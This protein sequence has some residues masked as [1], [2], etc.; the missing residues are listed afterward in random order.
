MAVSIDLEVIGSSGAASPERRSTCFRIGRELAVDG[1]ALA[2]GIPVEEQPGVR[3][4]L[5]TH[6]H[7][8]H[9]RELPLFLDNVLALRS[10]AE[11]GGRRAPSRPV[12]IGAERGTWSVLLR[13]VFNWELW[14]DFRRFPEPPGRFFPV[15]PG[16]AFVRAG[17]RIVP[18]RLHHTV[19]SVGYVFRRGKAAAAVLG[20]TGW[21]ESVFRS[22]ARI[23]GLRLLVIEC[24]YPSRLEALAHQALHLTPALLERGLRII[25]ASR[26]DVRVLVSHLKPPWEERLQVELRRLDPAVMIARDGLKVPFL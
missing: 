8:D 25:R 13:H 19:P 21:R 4:V 1:G 16:K 6:R 24:S 10:F 23:D 5:L 26:P 3:A 9:I 20:D 11:P 15:V 12:E 17:M 7:F 18:I 22:L 14:P 2:S